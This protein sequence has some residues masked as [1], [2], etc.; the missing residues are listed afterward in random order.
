MMSRKPNTDARRAEIVAAMCKV[1]AR[2]GYGRATV[3]AVA[4]Q[5]HAKR[6]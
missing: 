4:A 3:Q 2:T 5:G 6:G 1:M